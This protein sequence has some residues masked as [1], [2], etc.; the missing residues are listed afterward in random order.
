MHAFLGQHPEDVV[1]LSR[2][3]ESLRISDDP[4]FLSTD[5]RGWSRTAKRHF[6]C[7]AADSVGVV[8]LLL[9]NDGRSPLL[10]AWWP[11]AVGLSTA[12]KYPA[13]IY[14]DLSTFIVIAAAAPPLSFVV[15]R[16]SLV[17]VV[18]VVVVVL[19]WGVVLGWW[20]RRSSS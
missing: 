7:F 17:V 12:V 4:F 19:F 9:L 1:G 10:S 16:L 20:V 5:D 13:D 18:V 15:L 6:C 14:H 2:S 3:L 8:R 11:V